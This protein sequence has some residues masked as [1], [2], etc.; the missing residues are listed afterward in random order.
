M[1]HSR[2]KCN[3][4]ALQGGIVLFSFFSPGN[5]CSLLLY[6]P[7]HDSLTY[8][9]ISP[10]ISKQIHHD[11]NNHNTPSPFKYQKKPTGP[12][13]PV[14]VLDPKLKPYSTCQRR[15]PRRARARNPNDKPMQFHNTKSSK[16]PPPSI[17]LVSSSTVPYCRTQF[18]SVCS[19]LLPPRL[20]RS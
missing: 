3:S 18:F 19:L 15:T 2:S 8:R 16:G 20:C 14:A 4:F 7:S 11:Q 10:P 17:P 13:I 6:P 9:N 1:I 12:S 5:I